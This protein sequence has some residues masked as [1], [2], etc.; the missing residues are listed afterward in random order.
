MNGHRGKTEAKILRPSLNYTNSGRR[1]QPILAPLSMI[2]LL[3][4]G[5]Q[6]TDTQFITATI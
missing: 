5:G 6:S 4:C 3:F 1:E 2:L